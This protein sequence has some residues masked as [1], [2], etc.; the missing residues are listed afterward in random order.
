MDSGSAAKHEWLEGPLIK[1]SIF[2]KNN[3]LFDQ[4]YTYRVAGIVFELDDQVLTRIVHLGVDRHPADRT[5]IF[6]DVYLVTIHTRDFNI[7]VV[8]TG[9]G[10]IGFFVDIGSP[11]KIV[12]YL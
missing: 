6:D 2:R 3:N 11:L 4:I 12:R 8:C 10:G 1:A 7:F 9:D 5:I